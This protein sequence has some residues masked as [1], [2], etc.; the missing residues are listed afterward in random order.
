VS[1][2]QRIRLTA[3][4]DPRF[5]S[6]VWSRDKAS[7]LNEY[8]KQKKFA[9]VLSFFLVFVFV[10]QVEHDRIPGTERTTTFPKSL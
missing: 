3:L 6:Y 1:Q 9:Q 2:F 10:W 5:L 7:K 8:S 4:M